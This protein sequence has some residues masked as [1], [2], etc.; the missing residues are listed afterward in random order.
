MLGK[1]DDAI[2]A[3]GDV[4][5]AID[6]DRISARD[7]AAMVERF[8]VLER[9]TVA[10]RT[11]AGRL[12]ER[13]KVW[14]DEGFST[15]ARWMASKAQTTLTAA[16][17]TIETGRRLE[18]LPETS[19]AVRS[20]SLSGV[21]TAE[22]ALAA[23]AD[24]ASE[25]KLLE[26][27]R[28]DTVAGLREQCRSVVAAVSTDEDAD[29]R[30][31]R[32]RYLRSWLDADGSFR[33]D[34]RM[35]PDAGARLMGRVHARGRELQTAARRSGASER[36]EASA[37]DAL[38]SLVEGAAVGASAAR[39]SAVVHV[40][41]NEKAWKRG[42]VERGES[43]RI[44]GVGPISV[45][46]ARRLALDGVIKEVLTEGADVRAVAHLGRTIPA[47]LRAALEAR[48]TACVVP[49]CDESRNLEIDHIVPLAEGGPTILGNLARLCR[50]HHSLKTHRGWRLTGEPGGW[51]FF[52]PK[53][54]AA[55]PPPD[56]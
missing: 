31:H 39:S 33:L 26:A 23:T 25:R 32:G 37:A 52:K 36:A 49:G 56:P 5:D 17:A 11:L 3:V 45:A 19:S 14:R 15:P 47:R 54:S 20:G 43:C 40:L 53:R 6:V 13:S 22:I 38:L 28:I 35:T 12:V 9:L 51:E 30:I 16:A 41:V 29:E 24:P 46:A 1:L 10:G 21:Q 2:A 55:R 27:A 34:G 44:P 18:H 8:A 50:W 42:R 7:A 4:V 48:D